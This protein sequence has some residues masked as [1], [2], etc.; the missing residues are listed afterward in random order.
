MMSRNR[1]VSCCAIDANISK[2]RARLP[3]RFLSF[4]VSDA[5]R[6]RLR[7]RDAHDSISAV[8]EIFA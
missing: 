3:Y 5:L 1:I 7:F 2:N 4:A 8:L 6:A